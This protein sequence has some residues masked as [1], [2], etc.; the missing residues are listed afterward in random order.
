VLSFFCLRCISIVGDELDI[1]WLVVCVPISC[2]EGSVGSCGKRWK[3]G[4]E[5]ILYEFDV[6][7]KSVGELEGF[8]YCDKC[9]FDL[10]RN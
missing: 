8:I 5:A 1:L 3:V 9:N 10:D 2:G 7:A 6:F 4:C